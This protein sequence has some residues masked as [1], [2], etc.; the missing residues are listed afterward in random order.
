[1]TQNDRPFVVETD[2]INVFLP[3]S[4]AAMTLMLEVARGMG[5][6]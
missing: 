1:M 3:M 4:I 5:C 2:D 6:S